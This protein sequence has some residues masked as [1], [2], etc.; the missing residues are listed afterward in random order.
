MSEQQII[1]TILEG[2]TSMFKLLVDKYQPL[3]FRTVVGFVHAKEEAEDITQDVFLT[4]FQSLH[5]FKGDSEFSTWLYR[6]AVNTSLNHINR[7][8]RRNFFQLAES[9]VH[10]FFDKPD[11]DGSPEQKLLE[12]ERNVAIQ[13]AIDSLSDKQ[14]TAFILSKYDELSQKEIAMIM[15]TSEGSVEQHLQRAKNNLQKKLVFLVGK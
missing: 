4:V 13:K 10:N 12:A 8:K 2:K 11:T 15:Q 1:Q 3:I 9:S 7:Q 5:K 6:I 14:R